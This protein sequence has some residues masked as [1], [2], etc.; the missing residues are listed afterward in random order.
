MFREVGLD[1]DAMH[2]WHRLFETRHPEEHE[3]FLKWLGLP[4][5]KIE[6]IRSRSR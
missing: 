2:R 6:Q 3:C 4:E 5:K 1:E